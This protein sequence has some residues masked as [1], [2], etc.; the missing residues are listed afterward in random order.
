MV[1]KTSRHPDPFG[2]SI[3][4]IWSPQQESNLRPLAK[5]PYT[6]TVCPPGPEPKRHTA[7]CSAMVKMLKT[8]DD[9]TINQHRDEM[10][11]R[12]DSRTPFED[13]LTGMVEQMRKWRKAE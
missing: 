2:T 3:H 13:R 12:P 1:S 5:L 6:Y 11:Y 8:G 10:L 7:S 4:S 9:L